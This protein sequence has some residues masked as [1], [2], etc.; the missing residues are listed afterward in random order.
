MREYR[1][2]LRRWSRI[3]PELPIIWIHPGRQ[4]SIL[5]VVGV[6]RSLRV[7]SHLLSAGH[8][9]MVDL[10]TG[11]DLSPAVL[12][13]ITVAQSM[14]DECCRHLDGHK[15]R[16]QIQKLTTLRTMNSLMAD[17]AA[18]FTEVL[19]ILQIKSNSCKLIDDP[20][21]TVFSVT[22]EE[23]TLNV[24]GARHTALD[25]TYDTFKLGLMGLA[26]ITDGMFWP[27]KAAPQTAMM[28]LTQLEFW[29]S[30]E[31]KSI[32][33]CNLSRHTWTCFQSRRQHRRRRTSSCPRSR[34]SSLYYKS[35]PSAYASFARPIK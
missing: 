20:K 30:A 22:V 18:G 24:V 4:L 7:R 23:Y 33:F 9:R 14:M 12:A 6:F 26:S 28:V 31:P 11:E 5:R 2:P 16:S 17:Y 34:G 35:S 29:R 19:A 27:L 8:A 15:N 1:I 10:L 21:T 25:A 32:N 13:T 3:S